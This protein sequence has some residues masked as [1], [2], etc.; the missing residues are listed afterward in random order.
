MGEIFIF[1]LDHTYKGLRE[2]FVTKVA[3]L[4]IDFE[5]LAVTQWP[6][7]QSESSQIELV[8]KNSIYAS[9]ELRPPLSDWEWPI[10]G[11]HHPPKGGEM[12][13]M[14]KRTR[15]FLKML[16]QHRPQHEVVGSREDRSVRT[17]T[18]ILLSQPS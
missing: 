1:N 12:T 11:N 13:A 10:I 3:S 17:T 4:H 9:G 7:P 5:V 16:E 14:K 18:P 8:D 6:R 2:T 15:R